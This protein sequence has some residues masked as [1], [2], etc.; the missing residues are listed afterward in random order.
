MLR[1]WSVWS[2][3]PVRFVSCVWLNSTTQID[4]IDGI[5]QTDRAIGSYPA[6]RSELDFLRFGRDNRRQ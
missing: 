2:I 6:V 5:D 1:K 3:R 4:Q